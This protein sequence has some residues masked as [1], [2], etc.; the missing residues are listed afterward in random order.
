MQAQHALPARSVPGHNDPYCLLLANLVGNVLYEIHSLLADEHVR[1][2]KEAPILCGL[3]SFHHSEL[4]DHLVGQAHHGSD[5]LL[6]HDIL[7]AQRSKAGDLERIV[8]GELYPLSESFPLAR[9]DGLAGV[10]CLLLLAAKYEPL[11]GTDVPRQAGVF[12]GQ[13]GRRGGE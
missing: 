8:V 12:L 5:S 2:S 6:A 10:S 7:G 3:E 9:R 13:L 4:V 11:A 1:T